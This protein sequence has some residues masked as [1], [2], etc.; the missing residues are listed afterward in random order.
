VRLDGGLAEHELVGDLAVGQTVR[1]QRE[2]LRAKRASAASAAIG[3]SRPG[4]PPPDRRIA[5]LAFT[6]IAMDE[7]E[8]LASSRPPQKARELASALPL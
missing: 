2:H 3:S 1:D 7:E 6:A 4:R 8:K 5:H